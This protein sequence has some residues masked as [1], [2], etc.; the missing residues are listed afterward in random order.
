V[1]VKD[2]IGLLEE[3]APLFLQE[4][5]DNS[6]LQWGDP[7]RDVKKVLV[8]LDFTEQSLEAA[9]KENAGLIISHH[10]PLFKPLRNINTAAGIGAMIAECIKRDI[11]VYAMHTNYDTAKDGLNYYLAKTLELEQVTA[12]KTHYREALY[13]LV[14]FIPEDSLSAVRSAMYEA[15]AGWIEKYSHCGF[16]VKGNGTFKPLEG[17]NPY[18]GQTGKLETVD[19]YRLETIVPENLL[20]SVI[21]SMLKAH[22]YEEVA[23]DVYRLE[24]GGHEYSLGTVGKLTKG[25][26][27][28]EFISHV[29]EKLK[30]S[31]VRIIGSVDGKPINSVAVFCG[32]F[33]GDIKPLV[34]KN[35]DALVT[36]DLK[37]HDAQQLKQS[38]IFTVDAGH[39]YTEKLFVMAISELLKSSFKDVII[40]EHYEQDV[41]EYR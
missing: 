24:N 14:V 35:A 41:F 20:D 10:P 9:A 2:I 19:E 29:K 30:V 37:Y 15:G 25:M 28:D 36:G 27:P 12:L 32:S 11:C 40:I 23:Y 4:S 16:F 1:L 7:E 13:K 3:K 38:G 22:P 34:Q 6:G 21:Q 5:Y 26:K 33:D 31:N 39:Y 18:I 8:C 17:T